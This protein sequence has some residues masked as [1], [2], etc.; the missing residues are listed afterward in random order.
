MSLKL[1]MTDVVVAVVAVVAVAH[2]ENH[3]NH[4]LVHVAL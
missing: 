1:R 4:T 2:N 3:D